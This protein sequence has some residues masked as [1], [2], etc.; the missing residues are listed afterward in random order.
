MHLIAKQ[1][2]AMHPLES[3]SSLETRRGQGAAYIG[4]CGSAVIKDFS[5]QANSRRG[6]EE[7]SLTKSRGKFLKLFSSSRKIATVKVRLGDRST[8]DRPNRLTPALRSGFTP[9]C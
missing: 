9:R 7:M 8:V 4:G 2:D 6:A 3:T 1:S 5:P